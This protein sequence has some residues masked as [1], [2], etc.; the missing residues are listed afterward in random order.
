M[1]NGERLSSMHRRNIRV[2][3]RRGVTI[4]RGDGVADLKTFYRLHIV[5]RKRLGV[6]VQPWKFFELIGRDMLE[7]GLGHI[8]LAYQ[9]NECIASAVFL[10]WNKILTYKYGASNASSLQSKPNDLLFWTAIDWGCKN[11]FT[12]LDFGRTDYSNDGLRAFKS[13]WGAEEKPLIYYSLPASSHNNN[14]SRIIPIVKSIIRVS[15]VWVT[16]ALGEFAYRF[17]G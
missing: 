15:P 1:I 13:G 17:F 10:Y 11:G 8:L 2:A 9:N 12:S 3:E 7:K 4:E 14:P 16:R 5:T 6:P